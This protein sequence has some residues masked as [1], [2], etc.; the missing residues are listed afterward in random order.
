[1]A[2]LIELWNGVK[3]WQPCWKE[4]IIEAWQL[5]VNLASYG[6]LPKE[7]LAREP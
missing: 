7:Y 6:D 1:M 5:L 2:M 3:I 4:K